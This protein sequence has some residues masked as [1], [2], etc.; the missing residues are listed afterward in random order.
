MTR[1]AVPLCL[2]VLL[3]SPAFAQSLGEPLP[4]RGQAKERFDPAKRG[5]ASSPCP[6]YGPGWVRLDGSTT[7]VRVGGAV[8]M[9][10]GK[11]SRQSGL[12]TSTGGM[13]QLESRSETT[14]GPVRG[15]MRVQGD[16]SRNLETGPYPYSRW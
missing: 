8:R 4:G 14:L 16:I 7:C 2:A 15:V 3:A 6:E 1:F 12:G 13:V 9:D 5:Q 11:S 10:V